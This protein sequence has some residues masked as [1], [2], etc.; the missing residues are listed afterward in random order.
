MDFFIVS[1]SKIKVTLTKSEAQE[2]GVT[3]G[4]FAEG[5]KDKRKGLRKILDEAKQK[6]GFDV[7][8]EKV[9]V[10]IYPGKD[11]GME[12][13][14]TKLG[15]LL[16]ESEGD[17]AKNAPAPRHAQGWNY[18]IFPDFSALLGAARVT[19]GGEIESTLYR[20]DGCEYCLSIY[21]EELKKDAFFAQ[22]ILE[23]SKKLNTGPL[24]SPTEHSKA[25]I[26]GNALKVLSRL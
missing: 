25:V 20:F 12:L 8:N 1:K 3:S 18:Y 17:A 24:F 4:E 14:I 5:D 6:S 11:G 19:R 10:Q 7:G 2:R 23:F 9:L 22:A 13:F 21:K 16:H 26:E 15:P